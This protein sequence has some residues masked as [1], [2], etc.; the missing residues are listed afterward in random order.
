MWCVVQRFLSS[1]DGVAAKGIA[2]AAVQALSATRALCSS[3]CFAH[4]CGAIALHLQHTPD[5]NAGI[6]LDVEK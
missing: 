2:I 5:H 4:P 1:L 6:T 3:L